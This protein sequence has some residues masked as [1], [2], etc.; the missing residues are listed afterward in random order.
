MSEQKRGIGDNSKTKITEAKIFTDWLS[1]ETKD[2]QTLNPVDHEL[3]KRV[4]AQLKKIQNIVS[5]CVDKHTASHGEEYHF[6]SEVS[7]QKDIEKY[8]SDP[9]FGLWRKP[10]KYEK[11]KLAVETEQDLNKASNDLAR[12]IWVDLKDVEDKDGK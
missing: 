1:N 11:Q 5:K 6:A 7:N 8:G 10:T 12:M 2:Y 3:I 4:K 9:E